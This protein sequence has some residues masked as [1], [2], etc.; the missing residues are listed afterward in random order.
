M[1]CKK[2]LRWKLGTSS[3]SARRPVQ[4]HWVGKSTVRSLRLGLMLDT[5]PTLRWVTE[6]H[7]YLGVVTCGFTLTRSPT[8]KYQEIKI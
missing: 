6:P 3:I 1:K 4:L 5:R 2:Y 8:W 7:L